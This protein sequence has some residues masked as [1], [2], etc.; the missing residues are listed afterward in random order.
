M[1]VRTLRQARG[2]GGGK[3]IIRTSAVA[4][5]RQMRCAKCGQMCGPHLK[6]DGKE[7]YK[8][9]ACGAEFTCTPLSP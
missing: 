7:T 5:I 4:G 3:A 2:I 9:M 8:C 6:P 1:R